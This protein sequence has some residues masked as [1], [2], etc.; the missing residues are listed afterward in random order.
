VTV[1]LIAE[2]APAFSAVESIGGSAAPCNVESAAVAASAPAPIRLRRPPSTEPPFGAVM[3]G[4]ARAAVPAT[5][6][7]RI[8]AV[9]ATPPA[10]AVAQRYVRT[11]VEVLN[12]FRPASHLRTL[13]GPVEFGAIVNQLTRRRNGR[14]HF[15]QWPG[16][17]RASANAGGPR[18]TTPGPHA[19][20]DGRGTGRAAARGPGAAL[21]HPVVANAAASRYG[22]P[23]TAAVRN[24]AG[25]AQPY[26]VHRMRVTEIR[27]G[28]AEVVAVLGF[29]G[30]SLAM[31]MRLER[32]G[33]QWICA[34]A[35]VI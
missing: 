9:T 28:V 26:R 10:T 16:S 27:D 6:R 30:A 35:Q 22:G 2:A 17:V 23:G 3:P 1:T 8:P 15:A 33:G 14:G 11:C 25:A 20:V 4:T 21:R 19:L 7:P 34:V 5:G 29:G 24:S 13:A 18:P 31:A 12:G 32:R